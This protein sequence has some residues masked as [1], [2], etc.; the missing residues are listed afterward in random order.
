MSIPQPGQ[1]WQHY[2]HITAE[3]NSYT[4]EIVA[5]GYDTSIDQTTVIYRPIYRMPAELAEQNLTL[6]VRPLNNFI[7]EME[8]NG[9]KRTRFIQIK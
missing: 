9:V 1:I 8:I 3:P 7:E 2:K 4:Y 6:F 5:L